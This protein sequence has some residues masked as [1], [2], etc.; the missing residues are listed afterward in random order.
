MLDDRDYMRSRSRFEAQWSATLV[1]IVINVVV[2][3]VQNIVEYERLFPVDHWFALSVDGLKSGHVW[4]LITFQF[5]HAP[6]ESGGILHL[7][8]NLF[9]I[10]VFGRAVEEAV[11]KSSFVKLY[12]MSGVF[13]GM[14]QMAGGLIWPNHFGSL[15]VGASAGAFGLVAAFATLFPQ[16]PLHLFFLPI[17][18]RA[19]TLL[20]VSVVIS[21]IG[22]VRPPSAGVNV[23][24][25]AH[26]GGILTGLA[27]I[28][29][30]TSVQKPLMIWQ[31][32]RPKPER[33]ELV[34][35]QSRKPQL[36]QRPKPAAT[37]DLPPAEFITK[38]VDPILDKIS[39]HG[40]QS[41][42]PRERQI[43]EAA[44]ARMSKR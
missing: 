31:P 14:L 9:T 41:L 11:G 21:L 15:V 6:I 2:F 3:I 38:E 33:R 20:W 4:Q 36:W 42:T 32:F 7:L 10:Y 1:V 44:R 25:C 35:V 24:H 40:I 37:E 18:F 26:L 22:I 12:L 28:R 29:W 30:L 16:Q 27:Y 23:A 5:L 17:E 19:R 39:A 43:L 34:K 13:G 8:G